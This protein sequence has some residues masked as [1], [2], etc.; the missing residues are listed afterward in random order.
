MRATQTDESEKYLIGNV[1]LSWEQK[2]KR[3]YIKDSNTEERGK[4]K[5]Y[6]DSC[7]EMGEREREQARELEYIAKVI[8]KPSQSNSVRRW[9]KPEWLSQLGQMSEPEELS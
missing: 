6:W 4:R 7:T 5:F 2:G 8:M 1:Q 9:E 3:G